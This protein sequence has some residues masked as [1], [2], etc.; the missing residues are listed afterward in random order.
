MSFERLAGKNTMAMVLE[1]LPHLLHSWR[2]ESDRFSK[3]KERFHLY[4]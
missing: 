1:D 3:E 4:Q 2:V